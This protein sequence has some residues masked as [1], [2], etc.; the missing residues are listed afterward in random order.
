MQILV[1]LLVASV[2]AQYP[3][4][5]GYY[6]MPASVGY[7]GRAG[8][9]AAPAIDFKGAAAPYSFASMD[10]TGGMMEG[11]MGR[12][13]QKAMMKGAGKYKETMRAQIEAIN[14]EITEEMIATVSPASAEQFRQKMLA[15]YPGM[16][17][18]LAPV[19]GQDGIQAI[20][21]RI[22]DNIPSI[23]AKHAAPISYAI[24]EA[25]RAMDDDIMDNIFNNIEQGIA[26]FS[27]EN[28]AARYAPALPYAGFVVA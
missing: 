10:A 1:S 17:Q 24:K 27:L 8:V 7:Y 12:S 2:A 21:K 16:L 11:V 6:S 15:L 18:Q 9:A 14:D 26:D 5:V 23:W 22:T 19:V 3:A 13:L 28:R 25:S 20:A 4:G